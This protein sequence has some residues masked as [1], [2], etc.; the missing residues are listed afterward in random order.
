MISPERH[1]LRKRV[2]SRPLARAE[3]YHYRSRVRR[4]SFNYS[5][6]DA[7]VHRHILVEKMV[8]TDE[9]LVKLLVAMIKNGAN[10]R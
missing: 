4:L 3:R 6:V 2:W 1:V 8:E 10:A 7:V 5:I 9:E